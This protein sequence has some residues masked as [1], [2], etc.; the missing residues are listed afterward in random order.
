MEREE[1]GESGRESVERDM[2]EKSRE[3]RV[4]KNEGSRER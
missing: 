3:K 2:W 4:E 1:L